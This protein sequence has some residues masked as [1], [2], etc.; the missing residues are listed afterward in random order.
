YRPG[1]WHAASLWGANRHLR[2]AMRPPDVKLNA[3]GLTEH[4]TCRSAFSASA[5]A[6]LWTRLVWRGH[7]VERV[8]DLV[9]AVVP[10]EHDMIGAVHLQVQPRRRQVF[11][12]VVIT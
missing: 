9:Q 2:A 1:R 8:V 5:R 6:G 4:R 12:D 10:L 3:R 7:E 11:D